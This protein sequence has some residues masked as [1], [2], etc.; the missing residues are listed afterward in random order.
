MSRMKSLPNNTPDY[1]YDRWD[2]AM[3]AV[4]E[5]PYRCVLAGL[6]T[7]VIKGLCSWSQG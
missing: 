4:L 1:G 2:K 6:L 5:A 7:N 3:T